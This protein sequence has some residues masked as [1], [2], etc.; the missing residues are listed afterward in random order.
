MN[1][2]ENTTEIVELR[3]KVANYEKS[4]KLTN[5]RLTKLENEAVLGQLHDRQLNCLIH[6]KVETVKN[7]TKTESL[8]KIRD[9]LQDELG[10]D[11]VIIDGH[12]LPQKP[13]VDATGP[14]PLIFKVATMKMKNDIFNAAKAFN[15]GKQKEEKI[16]V[17]SH[18]P[19]L[20]QEQRKKL[21]P[22]Y[23]AAKKADKKDVRFEIDYKIG[24]ILSHSRWY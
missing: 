11:M 24:G 9:V 13:K 19:R 12:R 17:T 16:T 8:K 6:G 10:D 3:E 15:L 4:E 23:I 22:K 2:A 5:K 18:L 14:R 21:L 20:F 1:V 7:E